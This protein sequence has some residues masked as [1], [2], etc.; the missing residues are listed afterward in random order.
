MRVDPSRVAIAEVRGG[1]A[2]TESASN[3]GASVPLGP[4][5]AIE[6]PATSLPSSTRTPL[7]LRVELATGAVPSGADYADRVLREIEARVQRGQAARVVFD[8]DNTAFD[9]RPR[10]LAALRSFDASNGTS[11]FA[12]LTNDQVERDGGAT[13]TALG[14]AP[15]IVARVASHWERTFWDGRNFV[16]D[17]AVPEVAELAWRAKRA[18]AEV[19]Y[20]TGR[21]E[22]LRRPSVEALEREGFPS[23]DNV[24]LKPD[25]SVKT[26]AFKAQWLSNAKDHGVFVGWYL[27]D[28][29]REIEGMLQHRPDLPCVRVDHPLG[30]DGGSKLT[31]PVLALG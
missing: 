29:G 31:V 3:R 21:I 5:G 7:S 30:R 13:A 9:T 28:S 26:H 27:T 24:V 4:I 11:Y 10:T 17:E 18:G 15:D 19:V 23:A 6:R 25:L 12:R 20:L 16:H 1:V 14:L 22:A 2:A 8:L